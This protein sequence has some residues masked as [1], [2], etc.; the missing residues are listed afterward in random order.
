MLPQSSQNATTSH[1]AVSPLSNL[2]NAQNLSIA[3][4]QQT[5]SPKKVKLA[6]V[7]ASSPPGDSR[8]AHIDAATFSPVNEKGC[9]EFDREIRAGEL[10]KKGR[11]T[12]KYKTTFIV[13]RP[14]CLSLYA[15]KE[16]TAL[17]HSISLTEITAVARRRKSKRPRPGLFTVFTPPR[18]FHFDARSE[19][20]AD[21]WVH[22]LRVSARIDEWE[23]GLGTSEEEDASEDIIVPQPTSSKAISVPGSRKT[24]NAHQNSGPYGTSVASFSSISSIG[25]ANFPG[26]SISLS[27][28]PTNND[29]AP[30]AL[31]PL[32]SASMTEMD[33]E[34]ILRS[35]KIYLIKRK[36]GVKKWKPVWAVLR[37]KGLAI[38]PNEQEYSPL[39]ILS[40]PSIINAVEIDSPSR[41]PKRQFCMQIITE[42]R[43]WRFCA[44]DEDDLARWLGTFK[45]MFAKRRAAEEQ[46]LSAEP[47]AIAST[48]AAASTSVPSASMPSKNVPAVGPS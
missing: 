11:K 7:I 1:S 17:R 43:G 16:H 28:P 6:S 10:L 45:S 19:Q 35:G 4:S 18:N 26:S 20:E 40:F 3:T 46:L 31:G 2:P 48:N 38:Y 22:Q 33:Q 47:G 21:E 27:V 13:L 34:R 25:A 9:F 41:N 14:L 44:R 42:E 24:S 15:D 39:L 29:S 30:K 12:K 5:T 36:G 8:G 32:R 37:P 23:S